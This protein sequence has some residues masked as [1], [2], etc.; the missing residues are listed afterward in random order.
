MVVTLVLL[1]IGFYYGYKYINKVVNSTTKI[2]DFNLISQSLLGF[3]G[4]KNILLL[5]M[6]NSEMRYGGGFIG[7]VGYISVE[8]GKLS[9]E[10]VRSVYYY[11]YKYGD[12]KYKDNYADPRSEDLPYL[13]LRNSGRNMDWPTN[14][15]RAKQ[16]F[17]L[18]SG[19]QV[20]VVVAVTPSVLK[21]LLIKYGNIELKDYE[22]TITADNISEVLQMEVEKGQDKVDGKDPKTILTSL[23]NSLIGIL[24]TKNV[25]ELVD[26]SDNFEDLVAKRQILFFTSKYDLAQAFKRS[27]MDG[28][29]K[30]FSGD[31]FMIAEDNISIDK[32]SAFIDRVL[33]RQLLVSTD[34]SLSVEVKISRTQ[35]RQKDLPYVD[36]RG[37][38]TY[39]IKENKSLIKF[40]IPKGSRVQFD[41]NRIDIQK[42]GIESGYDIYEFKSELNPL[43]ESNYSFSYQPPYKISLFTDKLVLDSYIQ[44]QNG[45]WPY[46]LENSIKVPAGWKLS[47]SNVS[48]VEQKDGYVLYD[49]IVDKDIFLNFNYAK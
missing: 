49:N 16:I 24:A 28:A 9:P 18:E 19:K 10:P 6:N 33:K 43:V 29:T 4:K 12:I 32:S 3:K 27:A 41:K 14:A 2:N 31:Y 15:N 40:A 20:D 37:G 39:L 5:F 34:G 36:P 23:G 25:S 35:K 42:V 1:G 26:L 38:F 22:K 48:S 8:G 45:G 47:G 17:E 11:D 30:S 7:T 13:N 21:A 44:L 46:K